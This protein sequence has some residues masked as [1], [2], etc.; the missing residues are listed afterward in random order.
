MHFD[1]HRK[2]GKL[3]IRRLDLLR[4][5]TNNGDEDNSATLHGLGSLPASQ[6]S[7]LKARRV[8]L[9]PTIK[10]HSRTV[11]TS[12]SSP[13]DLQATLD[14]TPETYLEELR[15]MLIKEASARY[16]AKAEPIVYNRLDCEEPGCK[17]GRIYQECSW[18]GRYDYDPGLPSTP[19]AI[20]R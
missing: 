20:P 2:H 19:S 11:S 10:T 12:P 17:K 14:P 5:E 4:S 15:T 8:S 6:T 7:A 3:Q 9:H 16:T 18:C 13:L 1:L